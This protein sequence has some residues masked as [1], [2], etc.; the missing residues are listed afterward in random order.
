[1]IINVKVKPCS[2][3]DELVNTNGLVARVRAR[4]MNGKANL[5]LIKLLAKEFGVGSKDIT[6]K[7]KVGREK[8]VEIN[9]H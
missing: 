3:R 6:I 7:N 4:P 2:D 1:M 5:A 9:K 8:I